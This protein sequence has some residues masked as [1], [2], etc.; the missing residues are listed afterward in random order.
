[1]AEKMICVGRIVAAHGVH[2]RVKIQS[3]TDDP[4]ALFNFDYVVDEAGK[5][6]FHLH[7]TSMTK[8]GYV[9][10]IQDVKRRE[11]AEA[12]RN[13]RLYVPR[14]W[15][16][17]AEED[18]FYYEDLIGLKVM[19]PQG[20]LVGK[21]IAMHDF[22]AGDVMEIELREAGK[23]HREMLPFTKA[24]VP[25]VDV[26]AGHVTVVL[27][28]ELVVQPSAPKTEQ[29]RRKGKSL[30]DAEPLLPDDAMDNEG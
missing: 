1:M 25:L 4:D 5:R 30:S 17:A 20:E 27:P 21:V 6:R 9:A 22:G 24:V 26:A 14:D 13:T 16:P 15:L 3:F 7:P 23:L 18:E 29:K 8:D 10:E 2:G 28:D 11:E 19:T 12:L